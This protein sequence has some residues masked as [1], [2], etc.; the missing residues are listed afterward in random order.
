MSTYITLK[1]LT[2]LILAVGIGIIA[3]SIAASERSLQVSAAQIVALA[4]DQSLPD[5]QPILELSAGQ[6]N[7]SYVS[8]YP[9]EDKVVLYFYLKR[10]SKKT[11]ISQLFSQAI[12]GLRKE[13][14][15]SEQKEGG[16]LIWE[17]A[18]MF[19]GISDQRIETIDILSDKMV[20]VLEHRLEE[21]IVLYKS[22]MTDCVGALH[23]IPDLKFL[24]YRRDG[25]GT[26]IETDS[27]VSFGEPY[28]SPDHEQ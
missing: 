26:A 15:V 21:G 11:D 5:S 28:E 10:K 24:D 17:I 22:A 16:A 6:V 27:C 20:I 2:G 3:S 9:T 13:I 1:R 18:R 12:D 7:Y 25:V 14:G 19:E 4:A 23:K 8:A